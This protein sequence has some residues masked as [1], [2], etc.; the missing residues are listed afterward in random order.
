[1]TLVQELEAIVGEEFVHTQEEIK[2]LY[3]KDQSP[4]AI[5]S[6]DVVI[7]P[8]S[9]E[10]IAAVF[11]VAVKYN[12]PV[13]PRGGGTGVTGGALPVE[14]GIVLSMERLNRILCVDIEN[15]YVILESGVITEIFCQEVKKQDMYF[16]VA[17]GSKESSFIGGN[18]AEN[19]GSPGSCKYGTFKDYVLNLEVVL[20]TGE[21]IWTGSNVYKDVSGLNLTSLFVGSEGVLG[22]ITK[23]VLK[24]IPEPQRSASVLIGFNQLEKA[25]AA[26]LRI[27][28]MSTTPAALE[29]ITKN[30][31]EITKPFLPS[32]YPLL[33]SSVEAILLIEWKEHLSAVIESAVSECDRLL[34]L[35]DPGDIFM[36]TSAAENALIWS[37]RNKTGVAMTTNGFAYRDIDAC[38]PPAAVYNYLQLINAIGKKYDLRIICFGHIMDGNIHTML[39]SHKDE[40]GHE[41]T[42]LNKVLSEIYSAAISLG[43]TI[44]GEHGIGNLQQEFLS[45]QLSKTHLNLMRQIKK[46]LDPK[47]ILNPG[48]ML[49]TETIHST[50]KNV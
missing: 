46:L 25:C 2:H 34:Q 33:G 22:I 21:I 26:A 45:L 12:I 7:R 42:T 14:G 9:P 20:A 13:T 44:S 49:L 18:I 23:A 30:A 17:P 19:A 11:L 16:P 48:K 31:V 10:Q 40:S 36:G 38:V 24:I 15:R 28:R 50:L 39:L 32:N 6:F 43:G 29:L 8:A 5:S 4:N 27:A 41:S 35:F 3:A 37:L 47:M 1:M